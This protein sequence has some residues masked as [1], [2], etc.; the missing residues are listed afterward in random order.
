MYEEWR[1]HLEKLNTP[2]EYTKMAIVPRL[3]NW[4]KHEAGSMTFH[5]TQ[6]MTNHG[7]F[8]RFLWKIGRRKNAICDFCKTQEDDA[9]HT[10]KECK[11]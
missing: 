7:C 1:K 11:E 5:L 9:M 8:A 4:M 2:G 3:E 6:L 10:L